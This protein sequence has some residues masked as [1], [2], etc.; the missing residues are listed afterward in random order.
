MWYFLWCGLC[1]Q[2][3]VIRSS[4]SWYPWSS[5]SDLRLHTGCCATVQLSPW[6]KQL[7][8]DW[9]ETELWTSLLISIILLPQTISKVFSKQ[10]LFSRKH[11]RLLFSP[12]DLHSSNVKLAAENKSISCLRH[13]AQLYLFRMFSRFLGRLFDGNNWTSHRYFVQQ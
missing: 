10:F 7:S 12:S 11:S 2:Q 6:W 3:Q 8:P 9:G 1:L 4:L 5:G 13:V